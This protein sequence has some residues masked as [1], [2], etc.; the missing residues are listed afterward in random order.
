MRMDDLVGRTMQVCDG[1]DTV[2]MVISDHGFNPFRCGIDLNFWLEQNGYLKLKPEGRGKKYLAGVDWS[3]TK[4]YCLGLAGIWLNVRGREAEGIVDPKDAD[5]L[6]DELCEKLTGLR[7]EE[8]ETP[9]ISRAFNAHKTY[10]GPYRREAPDIIIGYNT[11]Y[12]ASWEAAIGQPTAK[13]FHDN[14]KAWSGDHCI[15]PKLVPGVLFCNRKI[16]TAQPRLIDLGPTALDMFG[17]EVPSHMDGRPLAVAD[18]DGSFPFMR[19]GLRE[20]VDMSSMENREVVE[21]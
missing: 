20:Q 15:D 5:R 14:T 9:A 12:R 10:Q 17:V 13:L 2:L 7:D 8:K 21:G 6:R 18:A 3:Q 1:R 19:E 4:A 16:K 11:G